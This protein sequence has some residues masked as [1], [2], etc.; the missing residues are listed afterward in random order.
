MAALRWWA[1][2]VGNA[3][4]IP[5]DNA[6]FGIPRTPEEFRRKGATA[7]GSGHTPS[8]LIDPSLQ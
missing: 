4:A 1:Q 2:K 6:A 7:I 3:G 5:A 8:Q